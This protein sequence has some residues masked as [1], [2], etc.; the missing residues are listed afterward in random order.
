MSYHVWQ[1]R[2]NHDA[3]WLDQVVVSRSLGGP[4]IVA[5]F[6]DHRLGGTGGGPSTG[7]HV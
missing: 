4:H 6:V 3:S 7:G 5:S 2:L 1:R